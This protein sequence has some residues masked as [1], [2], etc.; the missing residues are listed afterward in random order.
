M[1]AV[2]P[3]EEELNKYMLD[4]GSRVGHDA[5]TLDLTSQV[6]LTI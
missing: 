3:N 1:Q 4:I 2:T 6:G 5:T